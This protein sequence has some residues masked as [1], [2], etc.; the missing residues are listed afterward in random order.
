MKE[1]LP[2]TELL[3]L[4]QAN[5]EEAF[6]VLYHRYATLLYKYAAARI[7]HAEDAE[8]LVQNLFLWL[9]EKREQLAHVDPLKA[10]L[11][12]AIRH[13]VADHFAHQA[14]R[15]KHREHIINFE[16][17]S[18]N[19]TEA[20]A[21]LHDLERLIEQRIA[22]L[23]ANCQTAFRLS[24]Q[25]HLTIAEVA[26]RMQLSTGTVENYITQALRELRS[27]LHKS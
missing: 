14:V 7:T 8:E 4:L 22:T 18:A 25:Q 6:T 19:P 24:R 16:T 10:Y 1:G 23:P 9:W 2:D 20:Q 15:Q 27:S 5:D 21:N 26:E 3:Q 12:S 13:R 17:F 11:Y